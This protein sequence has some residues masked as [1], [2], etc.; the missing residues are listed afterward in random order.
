MAGILRRWRR[1]LP[2]NCLQGPS[3][4]WMGRPGRIKI[5]QN[6]TIGGH[7]CGTISRESFETRFVPWSAKDNGDGTFLIVW[8]EDG[9]EHVW[10]T[11]HV[12]GHGA[13]LYF[14]HAFPCSY[15][16]FLRL[17]CMPLLAAFWADFRAKKN[18]LKLLRLSELEE[19]T[20][21]GII[22]DP[23]PDWEAVLVGTDKHGT[24]PFGQ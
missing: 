3:R 8:D 23:M 4:T 19:G 9:E 24:S 2:G 16:S 12:A 1:L 6:K 20:K 10:E 14:L 13:S 21:V 18:H 17:V 11:W 5:N 7:S 15:F 22:R